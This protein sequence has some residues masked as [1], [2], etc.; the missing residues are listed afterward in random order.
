LAASCCSSW[1]SPIT[2][3]RTS[4]RVIAYAAV[5]GA[6]LVC[7]GA[8]RAAAGAGGSGLVMPDSVRHYPKP[9]SVMARSAIV[10]GWGQV[11]N[12]KW[13]KA[14]VVVG[15]EGLL[16]SKAIGEYQKEQD[17]ANIGDDLSRE[18]HYNLKVNYI[19]WAITVHLLQMA[20]AYVDAHLA[21]FDADFG[22]DKAE[23]R[24]GSGPIDDS[25]GEQRLAVAVH[26]R[27]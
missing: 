26:V 3:R 5:V 19:W 27:F 15:G 13:I 9:F 18:S 14:V 12:R 10:P 4:A 1:R 23:L 21:S 24:S 25:R 20:D 17:A 6:V 7:F 8:P 2:S 22:P 16:I 11:V